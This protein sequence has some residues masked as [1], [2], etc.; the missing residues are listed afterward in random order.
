MAVRFEAVLDPTLGMN[1]VTALHRNLP[2]SRKKEVCDLRKN[3][4]LRTID[5]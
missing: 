5:S 4:I 2:F 3:W 1:E